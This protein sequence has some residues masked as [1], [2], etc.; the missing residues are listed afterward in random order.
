MFDHDG[1]C[2]DHVEK[3]NNMIGQIF[4]GRH[5]WLVFGETG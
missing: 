1:V 5:D 2:F 3:L 4:G